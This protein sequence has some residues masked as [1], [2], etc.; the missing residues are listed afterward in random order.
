M[1]AVFCRATADRKA[2]TWDEQLVPFTRLEFAISDAAKGIA[3]AVAQRA[4][5]RRDD[6]LAPPLEH[7]LDVFHTAME[8]HRV[9][10]RHWRHAEAAWEKA[11][12]ADAKVAGA[13]RQG[14]DARGAAQAARTAWGRAIAA[15]EEAERLESAWGRAAAALELFDGDGRLND[16]VRATA[17]IA[18]AL[19]DLAGPEWSKVRNFLT[20]PRSLAFL[21]RMHRR[22]DMA[23]PRPEWREAMAWRWWLRHGRVGAA[24]PLTELLRGVARG[25]ELDAEERVSYERVA[26]VLG[27]TVRA[28]SAV[29]C[30]NSVL[31]MQQSRH[32]RMTQPML[33]LKRLYWNC[34]PFRSGPRK[35]ACPYLGL[36]LELPTYDF[37]ELLRADPAQLTQQ[38]STPGD[39]E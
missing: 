1:T 32:K 35:G 6:P 17:A 13:K 39:A 28:S 30:M 31:R 11:E 21:D 16:R 10:A 4:A 9:L 25:R 29:E 12:G 15:F 5:A 7:G 36:G 14:I 3:K 27:A 38:L 33:D 37:W 22:L 20:D 34:R 24:D 26:A 18:A 23:E 8:A 19:K 2:A